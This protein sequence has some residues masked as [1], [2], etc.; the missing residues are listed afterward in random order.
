M[1]PNP[2]AAAPPA[3]G[4]TH[5]SELHEEVIAAAVD[6]DQITGPKGTHFG[7][8]PVHLVL[9]G[10]GNQTEVNLE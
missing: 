2:A 8:V 1:V 6:R 3:A 7:D 9:D 4:Q 5:C 10:I